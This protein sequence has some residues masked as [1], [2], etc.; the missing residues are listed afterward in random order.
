MVAPMLVLAAT[1]V[2]LCQDPAPA[3]PGGQDPKP[4]VEAKQSATSRKLE[5]WDDKTVREKVKAFEKAVRAKGA[6]M[7]Q[8]QDALA[9]LAGGTH[10][11]LIKPL[12]KYLER[13]SSVTLKRQAAEMLGDQP[14][15]QARKVVLKLLKNARVV[16]N[17]QVQAGLIRSLSRA[18]YQSADW[19]EIDDVIES[20][21]DTERVPAHEALL[22]L[23]AAHK[24]V[25]A[26]P[27]LLRNLDEPIPE[28]VDAGSNPPAEYWKAR[29]HSW[30]AW[31]GKVKEAL[32]AITGQRF[33]TRKEAELWLK[34][35]GR[36]LR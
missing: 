5:A 29:W 31:K 9:L 13:E 2:F 30:A 3:E 25:Q 10:A 22:E 11:K 15:K 21:Y 27:M 14:P 23:V 16:G 20:D 1:V 19:K 7:K 33:S 34:E 32:F 6:S 35:H 18:G 24:E 36:E 28:N 12:A 4:K 8:R 17:P 26:L